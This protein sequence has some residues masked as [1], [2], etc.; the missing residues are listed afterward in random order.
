MSTT[1][2]DIS[3]LGRH[4]KVGSPSEEVDELHKTAAILNTKLDEIQ[5]KTN[6]KNLEH[7]AVMAAL[8]FCHELRQERQKTKEYTNTVDDRIQLLQETIERALV[9]N[10]VNNKIDE[11][12][13]A[14]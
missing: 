5:A 4:F 9:D 12:P 1:A 11:T 8:N 7:L 13:S 3:I 10:K 6:I 14:V 2:V